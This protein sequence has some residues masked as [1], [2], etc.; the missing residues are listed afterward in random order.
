MA[1]TLPAIH[2]PGAGAQAGPIPHRLPSPPA[3]GRGSAGTTIITTTRGL[4]S[5]GK[6]ASPRYA[7]RKQPLLNK[8]STQK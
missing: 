4:G 5:R 7:M 6:D 1:A 3:K 2:S 8:R